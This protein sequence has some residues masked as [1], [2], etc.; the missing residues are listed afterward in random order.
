MS[1]LTKIDLALGLA[2][3]GLGL[4]AGAVQAKG[5]E[6]IEGKIGARIPE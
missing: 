2:V 5:K 6:F 3:N 4:L 1:A